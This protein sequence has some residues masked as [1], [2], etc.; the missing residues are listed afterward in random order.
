M[1]LRRVH[2]VIVGSGVVLG[3]RADVGQVLDARDIAWGRAV[4]VAAG[5]VLRVELQELA[6]AQELRGELVEL[7]LRSLTPVHPRGLSERA[8]R[9]HPVGHR[10]GELGQRNQQG[11]S[12]GH[13]R[14]LSS[15][16]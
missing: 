1:S 4:E 10:A 8:N 13:P 12:S 9:I 6:V 5:E 14:F 15:Y 7:R 3:S 11:C 16:A 2:P